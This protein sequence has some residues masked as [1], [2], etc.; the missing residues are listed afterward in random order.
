[1]PC[2]ALQ[3][4]CVDGKSTNLL[5][6]QNALVCEYLPLILKTGEPPRGHQLPLAE[7]VA[8]VH[9]RLTISGGSGARALQ[10]VRALRK[11]PQHE[12]KAQELTAAALFSLEN[13]VTRRTPFLICLKSSCSSIHPGRPFNDEHESRTPLPCGAFGK[14]LAVHVG[15]R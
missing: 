2:G 10:R 3:F 5:R 4:I 8:R 6:A 11:D 13:A 1:M 14:R 9:D 12:A 7:A 15:R